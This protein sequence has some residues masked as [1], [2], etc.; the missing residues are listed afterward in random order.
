MKSAESAQNAEAM[1]EGEVGG[2]VRFRRGSSCSGDYH[3]ADEGSELSE[4]QHKADVNPLCPSCAVNPELPCTAGCEEGEGTLESGGVELLGGEAELVD[5]GLGVV[6]EGAEFVDGGLGFVGGGAELMEDGVGL[7]ST[8]LNNLHVSD[9]NEGGVA[10]GIGMSF[11][12]EEFG[13]CDLQPEVPSTSYEGEWEGEATLD[14]R[15]VSDDYEGSVA[16]G[17][18]V[19]LSEEQVKVLGSCDVT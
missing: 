2:Y 9:D 15:Y 11:S 8:E 4:T 6:G 18:K 19:E 14:N 10:S 12:E 3:S 7:L 16:S 1:E 5:G 17:S 13:S